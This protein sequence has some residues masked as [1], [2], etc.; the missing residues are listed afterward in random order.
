MKQKNILLDESQRDEIA[1]L[2]NILLN[3]K[4]EYAAFK[5][6]VKTCDDGIAVANALLNNQ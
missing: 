6:F 5:S 2:K 3:H 1:K 4:K